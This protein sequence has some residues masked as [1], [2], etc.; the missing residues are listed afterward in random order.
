MPPQLT[1]G[2]FLYRQ[3]VFL[4][5]LAAAFVLFLAALEIGFRRGRTAVGLADTSKTR[6]SRLQTAVIGLLAL[7]LAFSFAAHLSWTTMG[8]SGER[9]PSPGL[10]RSPWLFSC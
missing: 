1:T 10:H 4:V 6:L 3:N 2:E 9:R 7:L 8:C 5:V